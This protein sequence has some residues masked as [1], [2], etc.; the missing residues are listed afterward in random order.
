M[1]GPTLTAA[2]SLPDSLI[3]S[4]SP[5]LPT[6]LSSFPPVPEPGGISGQ[7]SY[8]SEFIPPLRV[9]AFDTENPSNYYYIDT[10][11]NQFDYLISGLPAGEYHV[12]SYVI[13]SPT[14]ASGYTQ[15][16]PCGL[17]YG[18]NDHALIDVIVTSGNTTTGINPGDWY[19]DSAA[20]P[21][22]PN[23]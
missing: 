16:V 20:F 23:S 7:L 5:P 2:I 17:A 9:V 18:C 15:M 13:G 12:V 22:M 8:P 6:S 10:I 4:E 11:Q 3:P 19:G 14:Q 1:V 21:P